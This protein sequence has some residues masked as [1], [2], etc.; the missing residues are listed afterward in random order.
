MPHVSPASSSPIRK[1]VGFWE[2]MIL[3]VSD[4]FLRLFLFLEPAEV[5]SSNRSSITG[6]IV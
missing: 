2:P 5:W 6:S 3:A 1:R 4:S